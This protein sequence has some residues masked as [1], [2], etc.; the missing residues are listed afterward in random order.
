MLYFPFFVVP[1][2]PTSTR[3]LPRD[4]YPHVTRFELNL[5]FDRG[6]CVLFIGGERLKNRRELRRCVIVVGGCEQMRPPPLPLRLMTSPAATAVL[7]L[8]PSLQLILTA[9]EEMS[10]A[11]LLRLMRNPALPTASNLMDASMDVKVSTRAGGTRSSLRLAG[12][13]VTGT[14]RTVV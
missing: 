6:K 13:A 7:G 4:V 8:H 14:L 11:I 9:P 1:T 3:P 10:A 2:S 5:R 12:T